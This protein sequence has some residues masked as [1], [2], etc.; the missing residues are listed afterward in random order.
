[1]S[2]IRIFSRVGVPLDLSPKKKEWKRGEKLDNFVV[3]FNTYDSVYGLFSR[4]NLWQSSNGVLS[5]GKIHEPF[6]QG[7]LFAFTKYPV[8]VGDVCKE[9]VIESDCE[10]LSKFKLWK[11]ELRFG[12]PPAP[13]IESSEIDLLNS[14]VNSD[15]DLSE[16]L[17][18]L[19]DK[20][21]KEI[22]P[23]CVCPAN[24]PLNTAPATASY[25]AVRL[26]LKQEV[27]AKICD[28]KDKV[29]H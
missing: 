3:P 24:G 19:V 27:E 7:H 11:C 22:L 5:P 23:L 20:L 21:F 6:D 16:I 14:Y 12:T 9:M 29:W 2:Q 4:F 15:A 25:E 10:F 8:L 13:K 17:I 18:N 26:K 28:L 1:M